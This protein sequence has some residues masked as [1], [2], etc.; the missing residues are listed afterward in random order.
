[1]FRLA[2]ALGL[3]LMPSLAVAQ[4][5]QCKVPDRLQTPERADPPPGAVRNVR[6]T[7][8]L[9][10]LSWSPQFCRNR[11]DDPK[12]R[13]QCSGD[14]GRF[15]FILHGLWPDR[16][17]RDDPAW[18]AP[19]K[20][21]SRELVRD[22]FCMTPSPELLQ[23]EWAKHGSCASNDPAR[24]LKA[25]SLLYKALSFP[26]MDMLSRRR[27]TIATLTAAFSSAN[28]GLRPDM[29]AVETD[30][31]N[32]LKEV[33]VCLDANLRPRTCASEDRGQRP[34]RFLRIWNPR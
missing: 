6:A 29:I 34:T 16:P 22:H 17:G 33:R 7:Q 26:D 31:G 18:C 30:Q 25:A 8:H 9:F 24:Y 27:I 11:G 13:L 28:P 14:A 10:A 4:A 1:M 2:L 3:G 15:G 19:A 20:P 23:H 21:L 32:W 12:H 5:N